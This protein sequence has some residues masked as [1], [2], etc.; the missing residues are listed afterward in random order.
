MGSILSGL[1]NSRN[2]ADDIGTGAD[3]FCAQDAEL[4]AYEKAV[5]DLE[6]VKEVVAGREAPLRLW[7]I[8][9]LLDVVEAAA[10][11]FIPISNPA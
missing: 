4:E 7:P 2:D 3:S 5:Q 1:L 9:G 11:V 10:Y 8:D 6:Q